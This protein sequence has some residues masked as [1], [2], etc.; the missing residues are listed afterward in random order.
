MLEALFLQHSGLHIILQMPIIDWQPQT[1]QSLASKE[2]CIFGGEEILEPLVKEEVVFLLAQDF[3]HAGAVL[4]LV[5]RI[6]SD[7]VFHAVGEMS[8]REIIR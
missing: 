6:A 7:E 1:I 8:T 2:L 3:E 4:M 5:A